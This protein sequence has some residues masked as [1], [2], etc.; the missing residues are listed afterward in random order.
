MATHP[1]NPY[2]MPDIDK[3]VNASEAEQLWFFL[4]DSIPTPGNPV[5]IVFPSGDE[6]VPYVCAMADVC[7]FESA[8]GGKLSEEHS[9]MIP[10]IPLLRN[11]YRPYV[12][13]AEMTSPTPAEE[14]LFAK[15]AASGHCVATVDK[16]TGPSVRVSIWLGAGPGLQK[17]VD[18]WLVP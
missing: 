2:G 5:D 3:V 8:D 6:A 14:Q 11:C 18:G 15:M 1:L 12:W 13:Q 7:Y 4:D 9:Y 10:Y 17:N 16:P